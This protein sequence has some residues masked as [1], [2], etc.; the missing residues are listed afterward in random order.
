MKLVAGTN[1]ELGDTIFCPVRRNSVCKQVAKFDQLCRYV[2][3]IQSHLKTT[4]TSEEISS[5]DDIFVPF[6]PNWWLR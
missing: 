4:L 5:T 2:Y 1:T 6:F 3:C